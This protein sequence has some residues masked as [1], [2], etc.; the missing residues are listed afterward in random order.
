MEK[1]IKTLKKVYGCEWSF[2]ESTTSSGSEWLTMENDDDSSKSFSIK[3]CWEDD[4]YFVSYDFRVGKEIS[5]CLTL[6]RVDHSIEALQNA[7][8]TLIEKANK[9]G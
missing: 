5:C 2:Y 9:L 4:Y 1:L 3:D 6:G 8:K 7:I